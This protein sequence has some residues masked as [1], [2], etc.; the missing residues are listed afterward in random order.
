MSPSEKASRKRQSKG[1]PSSKTYLGPWA[2][3]EADLNPIILTP[4]PEPIVNIEPESTNDQ[5]PD[6]K[7]EPVE[8]NSVVEP[9]QESS[10]AGEDTTSEKAT[11]ISKRPDFIERTTFH[12]KER[13]DYLGR[14][15]LH[16]PSDLKPGDHDCF[17]PKKKIHTWSGH[18]KGVSAI[19]LFPQVG[20]LLLSS[21]LEGKVKIW[22]VYNKRRVLRTIMAHP[23]GVTAI[24]FS[25]NGSQFLTASHDR[26]TKLWD[27]ETGLCIRRFPSKLPHCVK[28]YPADNNIFVAG[29]IDKRIIQVSFNFNFNFLLI[30]EGI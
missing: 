6:K 22:D 3:Y 14:T 5:Q 1:D 19:E 21:D 30:F 8:E 27:T 23:Q 17:L 13:F 26:S 25:S 18:T 15:Y 28:F 20:H 10:V 9:V 12:G 7:N 4:A 2:A 29:C 16:P 11:I 24:N